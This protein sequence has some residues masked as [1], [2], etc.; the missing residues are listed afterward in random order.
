KVP[1]VITHE[2]QMQNCES[3]L[4]QFL[5]TISGLG[6]KLGPVLFQFPSFRRWDISQKVFLARLRF[7]LKTHSPGRK[8]VVELRNPEWIDQPLLDTLREH[9]A[10]LALTDTSFVP[11]PW[12]VK[13]NLDLMTSDFA[14]VRWLGHR[15]QIESMT[16]SWDKTVV[17]RTEDLLKWVEQ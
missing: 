8:F 10:A 2:K 12:E 14:Y 13:G 15:H 9:A 5:E 16:D 11:R 1:Q 6:D 7:L 3:E 4:A 17:D